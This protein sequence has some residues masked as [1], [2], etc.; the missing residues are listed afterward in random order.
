VIEL[1]TMKVWVEAQETFLSGMAA[2]T[3][4]ATLAVAPVA[5]TTRRLSR[6]RRADDADDPAP[7][8]AL[9]AE[10]IL[11][12]PAV[13]VLPFVNQSDDPEQAYFAS[14]ITEDLIAALSAFRCFPVIGRS[15][16]FAGCGVS[17][18]APEAARE[19][20]ARFAVSGTVRRE[21]DQVRITAQLTD[22]EKGHVL[23][24]RSYDR[25]FDGV[26]ALQDE[27]TRAI[28]AA[29]E[30]RLEKAA[31][32]RALAK[33]S[34]RLDA[35]DCSLRALW[36]VRR[37]TRDDYA[38]ARQLLDWAIVRD[39]GSSR[40][41][42]VLALCLFHEA[43]HGW[44]EDPARALAGTLR[45]ARAAVELDDDDWLAHA[46]L[47]IATLWTLR[48]YDRALAEQDR[49]LELNPSAAM[50]HQFRGCVLQF[51]G[52]AEEAIR[53]LEAVLRLEPRYQSR[54]TVLADLAL[55]HLLLGDAATAVDF[56][57]RALEEAPDNAR[58][59]QRLLAAL[60]H[61]GDEA[62]IEAARRGLLA[63]HP[64]VT[65]AGLAPTYPFR[66]PADWERFAEGLRLA[67][68]PSGDAERDG[69]QPA[70]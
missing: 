34:D 3:F 33:P 53:S 29:I 50:S 51:A 48:D 18:P 9:S 57:H 4:L 23:W 1:E 39:P 66:D 64:E 56:A 10:Q 69:R 49:A 13:A 65:I 70:V 27:I 55:D 37:G 16:L 63:L 31:E 45:A 41:H 8:G 17:P 6:R 52:R 7:G 46:L 25:A 44:H 32:A 26:L 28:V 12:R 62:D 2:V 42:S 60:G 58:A 11:A 30:P 68:L 15:S 61:L 19:L 21:R 43:I 36:H 5:A 47:G 24:A 38:K 67:G 59:H 14:G 35:W 22:A 54:S 20:Q 40:A